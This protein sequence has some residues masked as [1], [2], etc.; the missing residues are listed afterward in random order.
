MGWET[1][2]DRLLMQ[3]IHIAEKDKTKTEQVQ[4][5]LLDYGEVAA[6]RPGMSF[7]LGYASALLNIELPVV[8]TE[9]RSRR[10]RLFG[11]VRAYDRRGDRE[12]IAATLEDPQ[13]LLDLL[14]DPMVAG[15]ALPMVVRSLFWS[16]DIKLAVRAIQY[17]AAEP[18]SSE[19]ETIVDAAV[20]DLLTR[21][22]TRVDAD[23]QEST[24]SILGKILGMS[25]FDRL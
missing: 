11:K 22:E 18:D 3:Q 25:G 13:M 23:D 19:L 12:R 24:A 20:T 5:Q 21:L 9:E 2:L 4:R 8:C 15:N 16:G 1:A 17:L 7:L 14:G 6:G 10:W